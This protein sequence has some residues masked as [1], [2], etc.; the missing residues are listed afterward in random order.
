MSNTS[1]IP[2]GLEILTGIPLRETGLRNLILEIGSPRFN[3]MV[4]HRSTQR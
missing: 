1:D 4:N 3:R 2:E